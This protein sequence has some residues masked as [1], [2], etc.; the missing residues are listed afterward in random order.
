MQD[1]ART[2]KSIFFTSPVSLA[3]TILAAILWR[4]RICW[5]VRVIS[6]SFFVRVIVTAFFAVVIRLV[7]IASLR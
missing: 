5:L 3:V 6:S 1:L 2:L 4:A 7:C